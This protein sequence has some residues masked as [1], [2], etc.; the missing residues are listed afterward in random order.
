MGVG[1]AQERTLARSWVE[2]DTEAIAGNVAEVLRYVGAGSHVM[3]V[4][5]A[6][7]YGHGAVASAR[8]A[9]R[10]G[11]QWLAVATADEGAELRSAGIGAPIAILSPHMPGDEDLVVASDLVPLVSDVDAGSELDAAAAR[12]GRML[13][14]HVKLDTGMG[15]SG[16]L[17]TAD[18][19]PLLCLQNI[20]ITGAGTHFAC[21]D[22]DVESARDQAQRFAAGCAELVRRGVSLQWR[23]CS[24]TAGLL[25]QLPP[26]ANL[27]R[28]GLL[29]YGLL[30]HDR[31]VPGLGGLRPALAW[32]ARL[33]LVRELPV[34]HGVGYGW[35]HWIEGGPRRIALVGV[36]Y[37]DGYP[38]SLGNVARILARGVPSPVVGRVCMD[39]LMVDVTDVDGVQ[40]GDVV[41]LLGSEGSER[42]TVHELA[43]M[44][45][46]TDHEIPCRIGPRVPR[47][48]LDGGAGADC[49][50]PQ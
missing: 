32:K 13:D 4:V 1:V 22:T 12:A 36:G 18:A 10:G 43:R 33:S 46:T 5:K 35:T 29:V 40:R 37:A 31:P 44:A 25:Q 49:P 39:A 41:T 27:V 34:G 6:D 7:G 23:H 50:V 45:G 15:R 14:V 3:A 19:A 8:A 28:P 2:V 48:Y 20:R 38:R 11:A 9:L 24:A 30:P 21:A 17:A 26:V 16:F 42:I 47:R